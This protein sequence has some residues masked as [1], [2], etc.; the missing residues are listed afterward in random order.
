MRAVRVLFVCLGNICRSP[1]ATGL[2]RYMVERA[3]CQEWIEVASAG[4]HDYNVGQPPDARAVTVLAR[5]GIDIGD[6]RGRQ[7]MPH[8]IE[9]FDYV[10]AMDRENYANLL[11]ICPQG[12]EHKIRLLMEYAPHRP[13]REIPD[14]YFGG[15]SGFDRVLDMLEEAVAGLLEDIRR[16]DRRD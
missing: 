3:G 4:T 6:L 5:R 1:M 2:F 7:I 10:I 12:L 8:D 11:V 9:A 16:H 14:P 15:D 13:E